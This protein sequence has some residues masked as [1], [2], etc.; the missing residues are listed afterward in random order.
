MPGHLV[1]ILL[2][3]IFH[4][5]L[6][7]SESPRGLIVTRGD[8]DYAWWPWWRWREELPNMAKYDA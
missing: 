2:G 4:A 7:R 3:P 5:T 6:E 1:G 8:I